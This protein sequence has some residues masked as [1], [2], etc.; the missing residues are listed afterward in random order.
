M[1]FESGISGMVGVHFGNLGKVYG[2]R[3]QDLYG[4]SSLK[5]L[6][7]KENCKLRDF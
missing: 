2:L 5:T 7:E 4:S 1:A 6:G 3:P